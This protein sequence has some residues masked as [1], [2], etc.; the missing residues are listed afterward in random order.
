MYYL[1]SKREDHGESLIKNY[2]CEGLIILL[3]C[4][5]L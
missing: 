5:N 4:T 1:N 2:F 3:G